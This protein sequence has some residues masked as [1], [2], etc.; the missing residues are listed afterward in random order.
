[1]TRIVLG[2]GS[3]S[4]I[5]LLRNAGI[6]FTAQPAPIDERAVEAPLVAAGASPEEIA[7]ALAEAKALAV[8]KSEPDALVIGGDQVL[9]ADERRWNKPAGRGEARAQLLA[10]AGRS[11]FLHTAVVVARG[12]TIDWRHH[13]TARMT[14]RALSAEDIDA[15]LD[16]VGD[17]AL[18]SVGAYQIE[19]PGI[20]LF[21]AIDGD[22]FAILG[23]P[24][25]SLLAYLREAGAT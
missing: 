11:H 24:L 21:S 2:S 22:Y 10:L 17:A 20:R 13:E 18:S 15:Y 16:E 14:M 12:G 4:R 8:S 9:S 5:A 3:G 1:M 6:A 7:M 25:L 19:G 23:L